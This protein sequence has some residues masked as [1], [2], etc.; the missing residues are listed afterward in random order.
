[1]YSRLF[2]TPPEH[3]ISKK[4]KAKFG[5]YK[6]VSPKTEIRG[7]YAPYAGIPVPAF[8]SNLRIK[9][10]LNFIFNLNKFFGFVEFFDFKVIGLSEIILW[11]KETSKKYVYHF[12]MP[13]R[14]R[15]I[16]TTTSRG[17]CATYNKRRFVKIS[18]GRQH[19][20]H[21]MT[22]KVHGD[23]ARPNIEGYIYSQKEDKIHSDFMFVNPSPTSSRCSATW[24]ATMAASGHITINGEEADDSNGLCAMS[25]NRTYYKFHSRSIMAWG[26]GDCDGKKII[27]QI[28]NT[29]LDAADADNYNDNILIIDG[30]ESAL[31]SVLLTCPFGSD[32]KWI[33]QDTESMVDLSFTPASVNN[34]ILNLIALRTENEVVFGNFEGT[35]LDS[36]GE[37]IQLKNFSGIITKGL[38]RL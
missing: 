5:T 15:F 24:L 23:S 6:G 9:S 28:K 36:Q 27:F 4:G 33:I 30:K 32:K 10:R 35:L 16:P 13:P 12:I 11:N 14:R 21:A 17:I 26:M 18:W 38:L 20:H 25:L 22:F 3:I 37:K 34:H 7:M 1:M 29:E 2:S 19:L 8:I 31:P